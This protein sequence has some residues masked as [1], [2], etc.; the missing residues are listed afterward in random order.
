[1][2]MLHRCGEPVILLL[3]NSFMFYAYPNQEGDVLKVGTMFIKMANNKP[4]YFCPACEE[5]VAEAELRI[6]CGNCNKN[7]PP[8]ELLITPFKVVVCK[9]CVQEFKLGDKL[10][11]FKVPKFR[12]DKE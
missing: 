3:N 8:S 6:T 9:T 10:I 11:P 12:K 4:Q 7:Y 5:P 1:M 2:T